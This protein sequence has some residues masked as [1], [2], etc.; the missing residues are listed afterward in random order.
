MITS[1]NTLDHAV[2][3]VP[4][5]PRAVQDYSRLGFNVVEG[6]VHEGGATRNALVPFADGTY[7]ELLAFTRKMVARGLPVLGRVGLAG[8]LGGGRSPME[9][10][11]RK[12]AAR[13]Y[14]LVDFALRTDAI[15]VDLNRLRRE[16]VRADGPL[17]GGRSRADGVEVRWQLALPAP[18]EL[19]FL[20]SDVTDRELRIPAGENLAHPN[21]ALG[22]VAITVA[23][24]SV[25]ISSARYRALLGFGPDP[26][27]RDRAA[28]DRTRVFTLG[29]TELILASGN[30]ASGIGRQ[31]KAR[32]EGPFMIHV[33]SVAGTRG[34]L[35]EARTHGAK[36]ELTSEGAEAARAS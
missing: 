29:S 32:G 33:R 19:P 10:R 2:V 12:R 30:P 4:D 6:G 27:S 24:R 14:G 11:F 7:L 8:L 3:L 35:D 16:G 34:L 31:L 5:L 26:G 23:V 13:G 17:P 22:I 18:A 9:E 21:G 1:T 36:I 15:D 20:C 25:E 28:A